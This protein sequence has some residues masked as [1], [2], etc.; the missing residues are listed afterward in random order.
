MFFSWV[1]TTGVLV[2]ITFRRLFDLSGVD[3]SGRPPSFAGGVTLISDFGEARAI[4]KP[5]IQF[6]AIKSR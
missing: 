6:R 4:K 2:N 5:R 1:T 3:G